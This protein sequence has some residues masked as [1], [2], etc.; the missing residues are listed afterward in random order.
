MFHTIITLAYIIPNIY[1]F[2]RLGQLFV[3]KGYKLYY[4]LI[5]LLVALIYPVTSLF[6]GREVGYVVGNLATISGYILPFYLYLFLS[7]L[8]FDILLLI[9]RLARIVPTDKLKT[10]NFKVAG[11]SAILV[12]SIGVVIAGSY[13]FNTIQVTEYQVNTPRKSAKID[14]LRICFVADFHLKNGV[15]V[16]YVEQVAAQI[17]KINPDLMIF[18]GDIVEGSKEDA[19]LEKFEEILREIHPRYGVFAI[20]G[21]HE[22]YGRQGKG[23]FFE[24]AGMRLINDQVVVIDSSFNLVGRYDSQYRERKSLAELMRSVKVSLPV[25]LID[26]RPT[27]LEQIG[28]AGVDISFS[29]HTHDGQLFPLNLILRNMYPL[30][31]GHKKFSNTDSFVTSGIRLWGP[32]V[33]TVGKSEIVVVEVRFK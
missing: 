24:K 9:N 31:W 17:L 4:T 22:F 2:V 16:H 25:I 21:N 18:G 20:F 12:I 23:Q 3:N 28:R 7:L 32:P 30:V 27:E 15:N 1:V 5:Y 29:G 6:T 26:H 13:N 33:R 11:L 10:T 8:L 14:H 19:S